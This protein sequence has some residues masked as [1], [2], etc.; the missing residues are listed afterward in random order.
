MVRPSQLLF[1]IRVNYGFLLKVFM[2]HAKDMN[3]RE[4]LDEV[5]EEMRH[6]ESEYGTKQSCCV[7][8]FTSF[9]TPMH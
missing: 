8:V 1:T 3:I 4:M 2:E 9:R 5:S 7:E 6:Y